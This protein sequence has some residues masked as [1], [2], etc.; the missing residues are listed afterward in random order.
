M[1]CISFVL[2]QL[3]MAYAHPAICIY[4]RCFLAIMM[5]YDR[6]M[7]E[8]TWQSH[9]HPSKQHDT[10]NAHLVE[11]IPLTPKIEVRQ[12]SG[13]ANVGD[14]QAGLR[15]TSRDERG[16][17]FTETRE[18]AGELSKSTCER[19]RMYSIYLPCCRHGC[20][21][22]FSASSICCRRWGGVKGW[23]ERLLRGTVRE[24]LPEE[25]S[26]SRKGLALSSHSAWN[27]SFSLSLHS[28]EV[29]DAS[30]HS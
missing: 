17:S 2:T 4:F 5:H 14:G 6:S 25:P 22:Q 11:D 9:T 3:S 13:R 16:F 18:R 15:D 10:Q 23:Q 29:F 28:S 24:P 30:S 27:V 26:I 12:D 19:K 8:D 1:V 21:H 7:D 20:P